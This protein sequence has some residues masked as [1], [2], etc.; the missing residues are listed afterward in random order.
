MDVVRGT[1]KRGLFSALLVL[2]GLG[3]TA[4]AGSS[5][6]WWDAQ[7]D[8]KNSSQTSNYRKGSASSSVRTP[9]KRPGHRISPNTYSVTVASG[10]TLSQFIQ[11]KR[12]LFRLKGR[13]LRQLGN[14]GR[15]MRGLCHVLR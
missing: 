11:V 12:L 6:P 9:A 7:Y 10:D 13:V 1:V 4:C 2:T 15:L 5:D 3:L 14:N 8:Y